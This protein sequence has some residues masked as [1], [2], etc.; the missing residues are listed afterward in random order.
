LKKETMVTPNDIVGI[1]GCRAG[2]VVASRSGITLTPHLQLPRGVV[3]GIDMPIGLSANGRR[4]CDFKA[5][6]F[7]TTRRSTVFPAPPRSCLAATDYTEAK[8]IARRVSGKSLSIQTFHL[9]VKIREVDALVRPADSERIV[10]VHPEC[11]FATMSGGQALP[12]KRTAE[13]IGLRRALIA[14]EFGPV[15]ST[16]TG[17][18]LDDV[19]DAFAVLWS[20]ERFV[21]RQHREFGD[22]ARDERGLLMRIIC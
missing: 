6:E 8:A 15:P 19:L 4:A 18:R 12:S 3:A 7:L 14:A 1:D 17:A 5:R 2:W 9:F 16:P 20:M 11:A 10:E 22:G 21:R 13:G